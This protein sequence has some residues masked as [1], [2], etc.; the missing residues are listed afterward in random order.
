MGL[1]RAIRVDECVMIVVSGRAQLILP[2]GDQI[3]GIELWEADWRRINR[4]VTRIQ[5]V[6]TSLAPNVF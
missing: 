4:G 6:A 1:T 5:D 2:P 3:R